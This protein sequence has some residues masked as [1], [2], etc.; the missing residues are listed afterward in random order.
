MSDFKLSATLHFLTG[1]TISSWYTQHW[2]GTSV[3]S[4][5][6]GHK[7]SALFYLRDAESSSTSIA[8]TSVQLC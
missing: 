2:R 8:Y 3:Y 7:V 1:R 5:S 6:T 4:T